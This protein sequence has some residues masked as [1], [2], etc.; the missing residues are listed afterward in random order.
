MHTTQYPDLFATYRESFDM[1]TG[2]NAIFVDEDSSFSQQSTSSP[3]FLDSLK[4]KNYFSA[5]NVSNCFGTVDYD[6]HFY[7]KKERL[8]YNQKV[9]SMSI[10]ELNP[11][12]LIC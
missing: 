6:A 2:K 1:N 5:L 10:H 8:F 3:I 7:T 4:N 9:K 12:H 11:L